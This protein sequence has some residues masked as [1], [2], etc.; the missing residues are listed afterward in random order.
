MRDCKTEFKPGS[1]AV[2]EA[3]P[4]IDQRGRSYAGASDMGGHVLVCGGPSRRAQRHTTQR[5]MNDFFMAL[6]PLGLFFVGS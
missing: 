1:E 4:A 2:I 5:L 6:G 3:D